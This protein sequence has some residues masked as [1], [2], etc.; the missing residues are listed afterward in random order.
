IA[1]S[2]QLVV[3]LTRLLVD[4]AVIN[5]GVVNASGSVAC[6]LIV[7][8]E[9]E[10]PATSALLRS[11]ICVNTV[12]FIIVGL[13][14]ELGMKNAGIVLRTTISGVMETFIAGVLRVAPSTGQSA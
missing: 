11:L 12:E 3:P 1:K 2:D 4:S 8:F 10:S 14:L 7:H 13:C 5:V 9:V 6:T